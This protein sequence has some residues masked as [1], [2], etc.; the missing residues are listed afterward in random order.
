MRRIILLPLILCSF[1]VNSEQLSFPKSGFSIDRLEATPVDAISNAL[2]MFLPPQN[3]FSANVN[4]MFQPYPG[5]LKEYKTMSEDQFKQLNI[6]V[7]TSLIDDEFITFEYK[8]MMQGKALHW[9]AKAFKKEAIIYLVTATDAQL[10]WE[11]NKIQLK[12]TVDSFTLK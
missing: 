10:N 8:G 5:S 4:V 12:S 11:T 2:H 7:I 3:G 9:Y 1:A 6:E